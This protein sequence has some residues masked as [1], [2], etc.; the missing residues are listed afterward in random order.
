MLLAMLILGVASCLFACD[1]NDGDHGAGPTADHHCIVHC[2]CHTA[3]LPSSVASDA[4]TEFGSQE[5]IPASESL[6]L[7]LFAAEIF[8]P[9]KA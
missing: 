7:R 4:R 2:L 9:P 6:K 5:F 3:G 8:N 1:S